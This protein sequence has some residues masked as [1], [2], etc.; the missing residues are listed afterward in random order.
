MGFDYVYEKPIYGNYRK[1][2]AAYSPKRPHRSTTS[3]DICNRAIEIRA[4][5][6]MEGNDGIGEIRIQDTWNV[7]E[8]QSQNH[9]GE[10]CGMSGPAFFI[11]AA[12]TR[13]RGYSRHIQGGRLGRSARCSSSDRN[14]HFYYQ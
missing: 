13:L 5:I 1:P 11:Y 14:Y 9:Q 4:Y 2:R 3:S 6:G 10:E 12:I 7:C 8:R